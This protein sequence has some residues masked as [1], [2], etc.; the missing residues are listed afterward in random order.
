M[1]PFPWVRGGQRTRSRGRFH[2]M[3]QQ[4][5][6][7]SPS[8]LGRQLPT[9]V[10][11]PVPIDICGASPHL[12]VLGVWFAEGWD[13]WKLESRISHLS[14]TDLPRDSLNDPSAMLLADREI[15][16]FGPGQK[17]WPSQ[18]SS[19]TTSNSLSSP[20]VLE[21]FWKSAIKVP[22]PAAS[23]TRKE[24]SASSA[25]RVHRESLGAPTIHS[26]HKQGRISQSLAST[27]AMELLADVI[28]AS[29]TIHHPVPLSTSESCS[30]AWL[31]YHA[32]DVRIG[33]S[34]AAPIASHRENKESTG[35]SPL[36]S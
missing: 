35:E 34:A 19:H 25:V 7:L 26:C 21:Q 33:G 6:A 18:L 14:F 1:G 28:V 29:A 32:M 8:F 24:A 12:R 9:L 23:T 11:A 10:L 5:S 13:R 4:P 17:I 20:V 27:C 15:G 2:Q 36:Q 30:S 3:F 31:F 16:L 22:L